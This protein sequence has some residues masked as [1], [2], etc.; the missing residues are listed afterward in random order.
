MNNLYDFEAFNP[1][2]VNLNVAKE[3]KRKK[4]LTIQVIILCIAS[5]ITGICIA[6]SALIAAAFMKAFL[7]CAVFIVIFAF[8][9]FGFTV[10]GAFFCIGRKKRLKTFCY[11]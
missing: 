9:V 4:Q 11:I 7:L 10:I 8:Y 3:R 1:P 5:A 6:L 2:P